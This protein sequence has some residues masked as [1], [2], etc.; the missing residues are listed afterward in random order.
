MRQQRELD[1][2]YLS[3]D[4][5]FDAA[6]F[7]DCNLFCVNSIAAS[8]GYKTPSHF[9]TEVITNPSSRFHLHPIYAQNGS[10]FSYATYVTSMHWGG[11]QQ[12]KAT[13]A[14]HREAAKQPRPR[15]IQVTGKKK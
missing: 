9:E 8:A 11:Q 15:L 1:E 5:T 6:V 2:G 7:P 14:I 3:P 4:G 12:R 10:I 13:A